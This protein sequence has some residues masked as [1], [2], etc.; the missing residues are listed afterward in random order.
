MSSS[1]QVE[2]GSQRDLAR[3]S[4]AVIGAG[5]AGLSCARTLADAGFEVTVF[6]QGAELGGRL[7]A[8]RTEV[9]GFDSGAQY[10]TCRD[11][12]F[13][14]AVA[15]WSAAG[16]CA[17]WHGSLLQLPS[18]ATSGRDVHRFVGVPSMASVIGHLARGLDV[19]MGQRVRRIERLADARA[20]RWTL[21]CQADLDDPLGIEITEGLFEAVV[22]ATPA[23][24]AAELVTSSAEFE[25]H[26]R[27]VVVDPCFAL[28]LAF[29][30]SL[31]LPFAAAFVE[32]GRLAWIAHDSA[33]PGR[34]PGER[35]I[36]HASAQWTREHFSDD[37][38]DVRVKMI[39]AFQE[40]SGVRLQ[41]SYSALKCWGNAM[42]RVPLGEPCLWDADLRLGTCGDWCLGAR[43]ESAFT[44]GHELAARICAELQ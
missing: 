1:A 2:E 8:R 44:S 14:A 36:A 12:A 35:W 29:S 5:M 19:R 16:V 17:A 42:T 9:G 23:I 33:K 39:K 20:P 25:R 32:S 4:I 34:R 27:R 30:E 6:E 13:S 21:K 3:S 26:I 15:R 31:E 38:E 10:M 11:P 28:L 43:I 7:A 18:G 41:P 37:P 22:V 40:V 24:Q